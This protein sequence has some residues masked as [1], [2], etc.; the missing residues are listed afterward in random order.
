MKYISI[1]GQK[2]KEGD[3]ATEERISIQRLQQSF[4]FFL[5]TP[6]KAIINPLP[7]AS[8][9]RDFLNEIIHHQISWLFF[10]LP[11]I[12]SSTTRNTLQVE[13]KQFVLTGYTESSKYPLHLRWWFHA[14]PCLS[15]FADSQDQKEEM[16]QGYTGKMASSRPT[17]GTPTKINPDGQ[18]PTWLQPPWRR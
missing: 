5:T 18:Y 8:V 9:Q 17:C 13:T 12:Y 2:N 14:S 16:I 11:S 3:C 4:E 10:F 15:S 6:I 1:M 7:L